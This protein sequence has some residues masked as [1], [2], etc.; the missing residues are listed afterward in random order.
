MRVVVTGATGNLGTSVIAQL[1]DVDQ[2][3]EIVGLARRAPSWRPPGVTWRE[4]DIRSADLV[5]LFRRADAVIHLAWAFGPSHRPEATWE[6]N[7]AGTEH[8]LAAVA[9]AGVP[10]LLVASSVGAYSPAVNDDPIDESWPT[11]GWPAANYCREK[12]YVERML[13]AFE[14]QQPKVRVVRF[15]P[16]FLFK[17]SASREQMRI[18]GGLGALA[19][20]PVLGRRGTPVMPEIT[21]L[22]FQVMHTD[23]AAAA[24]ATALL[25]DAAGAFNLAVDPVVDLALIGEIFE[26]KRT[27][28]L[29]ATAVRWALVAGWLA[30]VVPV[31]PDLFDFLR[32]IPLLDASRA[33]SELG[34]S[35][36]YTSVEALRELRRGLAD[37]PGFPTPPLQKAGVREYA[38]G[39]WRP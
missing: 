3:D 6:V 29:P 19:L 31:Q 39:T 4:V 37:S 10:V 2:V 32:Q 25:S 38:M 9:E 27:L 33:R 17:T 14:A 16:S 18:F 1:T 36:R 21:G 7:V 24:F 34:W 20:S 5:P 13:D 30:H 12:A 15:R 35:P 28:S 26:A 22:R 8:V 11:H 23:D